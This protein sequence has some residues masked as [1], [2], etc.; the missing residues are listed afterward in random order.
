MGKAIKCK[1]RLHGIRKETI[2][3]F[4]SV[5]KA[6]QWLKDCWHR[7]YTIVRTSK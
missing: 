2:I 1:V 7:P 5:S 6:K 4:D 3:E